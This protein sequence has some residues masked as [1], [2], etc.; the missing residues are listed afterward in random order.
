MRTDINID[1][2]EP[3]RYLEPQM[4]LNI[5]QTVQSQPE[6]GDLAAVAECTRTR[7]CCM[8]HIME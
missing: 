6:A 8:W 5:T 2:R 3:P 4:N 7:V 1:I